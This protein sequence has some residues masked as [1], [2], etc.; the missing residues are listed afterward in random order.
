MATSWSSVI[1]IRATA[2][3]GFTWPIAGV[4]A[5]RIFIVSILQLSYKAP[6]LIWAAAVLT[7]K[8]D[9][10]ALLRHRFS[11]QENGYSCNT[12]SL[13][14]CN[15]EQRPRRLTEARRTVG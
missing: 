12:W 8:E 14:Q 9:G 2:S 13:R 4:E 15:G 3:I 11:P 5:I 6:Q 10:E 7:A 1:R